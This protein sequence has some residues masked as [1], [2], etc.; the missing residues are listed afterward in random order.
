MYNFHSNLGHESHI[1]YN[2]DHI[3]FITF[4]KEHI[5][6]NNEENIKQKLE[7]GGDPSLPFIQYTP[8]LE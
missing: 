3:V 6:L 2:N 5:N 1:D 8:I 4:H 7:D